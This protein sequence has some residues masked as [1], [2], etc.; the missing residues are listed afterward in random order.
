LAFDCF[1]DTIQES[2][3]AVVKAKAARQLPN[4]LDGIQFRAVRG[5]E[6]QG[7]LG[8]LLLAPG[9]ME[10]GS[11]VGGVVTDQDY[12]P[13]RLDCRFPEMPQEFPEGLSVKSFGLATEHQSAVGGGRKGY[14]NGGDGGDW[15]PVLS[16][17][18]FPSSL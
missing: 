16:V 8:L 12:A 9:E 10:S 4:S 2:E 17:G 3:V 7:K 14:Q 5:K 11:V 18:A 1:S 6:V 13:S 15:F